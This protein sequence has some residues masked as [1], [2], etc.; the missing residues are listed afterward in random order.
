[1]ARTTINAETDSDVV[2][3]DVNDAEAKKGDG[4]SEGTKGKENKRNK[5]EGTKKGLKINILIEWNYM[6]A[7]QHCNVHNTC[8]LMFYT[9]TM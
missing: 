1:M 6:Y 2:D 9:H 4:V 5:K 3:G 7:V 8:T